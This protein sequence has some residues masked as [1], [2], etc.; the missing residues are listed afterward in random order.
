M[1]SARPGRAPTRAAQPAPRSRAAT[2]GPALLLC[3]LLLLAAVVWLS[4]AVGSSDLPLDVLRAELAYRT[5]SYEGFVVGQRVTRTVLGLLTGCALAVSG[6]IMQAVTR[7]PMA[8]PGLLGVSSGAS[9]AVVLGSLAGLTAVH[10]QLL[11]ASAGALGTSLIVLGLG[12]AGAA[13]AS[14]V[15]LVLVGVAFSAASGAVIQAVVLRRPEVFDAFRYWDAGSLTRTDLPLVLVSVLVCL[16]VLGALG[17]ARSLTAMSLG[18]DV[19]AS[20]G[21]RVPVVRAAALGCL[22]LLCGTATAIAGP[23]GFVGLMVPLVVGRLAGPDRGWT[24]VLSAVLGPVLM[25][26]ADVLGRLIARPAELQVGLLTAFVG[27]PVL[28]FVLR[29]SKEHG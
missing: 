23:I 15:R 20:L 18:D 2:R 10:D 27:S 19:A 28:L 25:L 3:S 21:T 7:N 6:A 1:K 17:I 4:L 16:G 5:A 24:I 22:T 13:G 9:L 8:E 29:R 11:L 14:P 12:S 26:A